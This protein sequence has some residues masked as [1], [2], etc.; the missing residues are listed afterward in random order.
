M[1]KQ[2]Y[3][4]IMAYKN[5]PYA[6]YFNYYLKSVS[7][8]KVNAYNDIARRPDVVTTPDIVSCS[9]FFFTT[10]Y[11]SDR[12]EFVI[13]TVSYTHRYTLE[14]LAKYEKRLKNRVDKQIKTTA[15]QILESKKIIFSSGIEYIKENYPE[16]LEY[17]VDDVIESV[18]GFYYDDVTEYIGKVD[19]Y[20]KAYITTL[21]LELDLLVYEANNSYNADND[22]WS[23]YMD[24]I[25]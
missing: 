3:D 10:V 22:A 17:L 14:D 1:N 15:Q 5:R 9:R 2:D 21:R 13:D 16:A 20:Q 23:Q 19:K 6:R 4:Y 8:D 18:E 24:A 12:G 25:L 7:S 11:T